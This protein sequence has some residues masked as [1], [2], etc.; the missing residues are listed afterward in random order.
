MLPNQLLHFQA[1]D[2]WRLPIEKVEYDE[3]PLGFS[4]YLLA[5]LR[6][7]VAPTICGMGLSTADQVELFGAE[8]SYLE[9]DAAGTRRQR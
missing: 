9:D 1:V 4:R 5:V 3:L 6:H 7:E 8:K 2:V